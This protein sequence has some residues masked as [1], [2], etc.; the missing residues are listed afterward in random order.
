MIVS[1]LAPDSFSQPACQSEFC[2][3]GI[4]GFLGFLS[5]MVTL[6][7]RYATPLGAILA[8]VVLLLVP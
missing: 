6:V 5:L 8:S 2:V 1:S 4:D 3:K 7:Q